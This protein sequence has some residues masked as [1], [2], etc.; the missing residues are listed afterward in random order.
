MNEHKKRSKAISNKFKCYEYKM[1][2][3]REPFVQV[4][5]DRL[6]FYLQESIASDTKLLENPKGTLLEDSEEITAIIYNS[7]EVYEGLLGM[8]LANS[9]K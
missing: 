6:I 2:I 7:K 5:I 3:D 1:G 8:I 4:D 9:F